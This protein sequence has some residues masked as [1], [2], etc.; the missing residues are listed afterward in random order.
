MDAP[1]WICSS[2]RRTGSTA[3]WHDL[4]LAKL[5]AQ[6]DQLRET[7][8]WAWATALL[9]PNYGDISA[10]GHAPSTRREPT[11]KE[12]AEQKRL[13]RRSG[14]IERDMSEMEERGA[15]ESEEYAAL[16]EEWERIAGDLND[17][18]DRLQVVED[19]SHAGVMVYF[20][21]NT[22]TILRGAIKPEDKKAV[23]K[24]ARAAAIAQSDGVGDEGTTADA[25]RPL[26]ERLCRALTAQ[27]TAALQALLIQ[28]TNVGLV[29]LAYGLVSSLWSERY[30]RN[31]AVGIRITDTDHALT[32]TDE[33][34]TRSRAWTH[35]EAARKAWS[36]RLPEDQ[37]ALWQTL[38]EMPQGELQM[39]LA[40][41]AAVTV[42]GIQSGADQ[43][44]THAIGQAVNLDMA[45]WWEAS[46]ESYL[47]HVP[48]T[49]VLAAVTEGA[50]AA[51]AAPLASMKKGPMV[52]AAG[53]ALKDKRWL[54]AV[55]SAAQSV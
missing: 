27:R 32:S 43:H 17:L 6:A 50:G 10:F 7:E 25:V 11:K 24:L 51:E 49:L 14:Q 44:E 28:H 31:S 35:I 18:D 34:I 33:S 54:P 3:R 29:T 8:G 16:A 55:L 5:Q 42:N 12:A 45:D 40:F 36:A 15:E 26:S 22:L 30:W 46:P 19:K 2:P 23:A 53:R 47:L 9:N 20:Q 21:N 4:A 1:R 38:L 41:C 52:E 37:E 48:K 39:L 13:T